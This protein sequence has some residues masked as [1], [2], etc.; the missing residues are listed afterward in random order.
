M[1]ETASHIKH[2]LLS[3]VRRAVYWILPLAILGFIFYKAD[4]AVLVDT[5]RGASPLLY[6]LGVLF[7][8]LSLLFSA[9]RWKVLLGQYL[10]VEERIG[11]AFRQ[12]CIGLSVG[13]FLPGS[14]GLD[15]YRVAMAGRRYQQYT[16]S[17]AVVLEEKLMSLAVCVGLVL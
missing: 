11:F 5:V 16:R 13:I 4:A 2:P 14:I 15:V 10:G 9:T 12:Y 17:I 1:N 6:V 8:P 3:R 7:F